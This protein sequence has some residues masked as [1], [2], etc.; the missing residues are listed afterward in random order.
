MF[1]YG[2]SIYHLQKKY[3][4]RKQIAN[5]IPV[6]M[7]QKNMTKYMFEFSLHIYEHYAGK[8]IGIHAQ[9]K[10]ILLWTSTADNRKDAVI[11]TPEYVSN[12]GFLTQW[13]VLIGGHTHL[14][15]VC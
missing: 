15:E 3:I 14:W 11:A 4:L 6:V 13:G 8:G 10:N 7:R 1:H 9:T 5:S 12:S 2:A